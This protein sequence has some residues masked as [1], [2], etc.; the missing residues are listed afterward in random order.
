MR[1]H[2]MAARF[3]LAVSGVAAATAAPQVQAQDE[4]RYPTRPINLIVTLPAGSVLDNM[5][6]LVGQ[7]ITE[8]LGQPVVVLNRPG[9]S[10]AIAMNALAQ[11]PA[12]GYTLLFGA[13]N[14]VGQAAT[15]A[16]FEAAVHKDLVPVSEVVRGPL[17]IAV[18]PSVPA[19]T[20]QELVSWSKEHPDKLNFGSVGIG[21]S[22]HFVMEYFK[23][24]TGAKLTHVPFAGA[25]ATLQA[26]L[27]GDVH[28]LTET[29]ALIKASLDAGKL[30][31]LAVTGDQR[32]AALPQVPAT[33]EA[34][35]PDFDF[36]F[37][38][39]VFAP[40]GTPP[41][42]V[43]KLNATLVAIV[44]KPEVNRRLVAMGYVP[45]GSTR[46]QFAERVQKE[47]G[48]FTRIAEDN[49]LRIQE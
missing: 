44:R 7:Q 4:A 38:M 25:P 30:R 5:A 12:D 23:A 13:S 1:L 43:T 41:A 46:Q 42:V 27:Q 37:W 47:I 21:S 8:D 22:A 15:N 34:G 49:K 35:L 6:R 48:R 28:V 24:R 45:V 19:R 26:A 33:T 16:R 36:G 17:V 9:A 39:G 18:H 31:A 11:A 40:T 2:S 3:L 29:P 10:S 14:L 20:V 32:Y